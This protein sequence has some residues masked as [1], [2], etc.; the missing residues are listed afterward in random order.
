M[1]GDGQPVRLPDREYVPNY[2]D[3]LYAHADAHRQCDQDSVCHLELVTVEHA[4]GITHNVGK[5]HSVV[6]GDL[7]GNAYS[8]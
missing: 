8:C 4:Y 2:N 7:A 5:R 3:E 6:D 1:V